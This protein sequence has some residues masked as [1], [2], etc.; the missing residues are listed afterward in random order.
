[1]V[2]MNNNNLFESRKKYLKDSTFFLREEINDDES[3]SYEN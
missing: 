3:V 1:M 2:L